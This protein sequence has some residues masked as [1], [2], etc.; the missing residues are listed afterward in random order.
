MNIFW[1]LM[2]RWHSNPQ[3]NIPY[4]KRDWTILQ[5]SVRN[6]YTA[7]I[8]FSLLSTSDDLISLLATI[9]TWC[10][11]NICSFKSNPRKLK[12]WTLSMLM[13]LIFNSGIRSSILLLIAWNTIYFFFLTLGNASEIWMVL[14]RVVSVGTRNFNNFKEIPSWPEF[15]LGQRCHMFW[16]F[17]LINEIKGECC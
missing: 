11:Q 10:F 15:F 13:S 9:S 7:K 4:V 3:A 2:N 12:F 17:V 6:I 8:F 16:C 1:I 14:N 5:Y